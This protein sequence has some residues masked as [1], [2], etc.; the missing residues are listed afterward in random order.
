MHGYITPE[1]YRLIEAE[2]TKIAKRVLDT[3]DYD[4]LQVV[5]D[6]DVFWFEKTYSGAYIPE[7]VHK[8]LCKLISRKLGLRYYLS[9]DYSIENGWLGL[10][11]EKEIK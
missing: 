1:V 2:G 4:I 7:Y 9:E 6:G 3:L 5:Q 10:P 11:N 8:Y